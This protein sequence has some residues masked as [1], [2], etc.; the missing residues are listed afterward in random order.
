[1]C[2]HNSGNIVADLMLH[3]VLK[4]PRSVVQKYYPA[5][6]GGHFYLVYVCIWHLKHHRR[7][8]VNPA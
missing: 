5:V 1:M 3:K 7:E 4:L 8:L 6:R 2:Y